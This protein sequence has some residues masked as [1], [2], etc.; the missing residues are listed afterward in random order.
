MMNV[1]D[2][3]PDLPDWLIVRIIGS[4][5]DSDKK[6]V[7][8]FLKEEKKTHPCSHEI[9]RITPVGRSLTILKGRLTSPDG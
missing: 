6:V 2:K 4:I 8:Y 7:G 5:A 9:F 1:T 3:N